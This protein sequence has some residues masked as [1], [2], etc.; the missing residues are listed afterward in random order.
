M[1]HIA[2]S[3]VTD[4]ALAFAP[5]ALLAHGFGLWD[6]LGAREREHSLGSTVRNPAANDL[7]R[8]RRL[9]PDLTTIV[10]TDRPSG[11]SRR[12]LPPRG[13]SDGGAAFYFT[14]VCAA[15]TFSKYCNMGKS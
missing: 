3:D 9:C 11:S 12:S 2:R 7:E 14:G 5:Y 4:T 6:V 10:L 1:N 13:V 15:V 8:L